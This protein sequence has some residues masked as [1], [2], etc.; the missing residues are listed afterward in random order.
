MLLLLLMYNYFIMMNMPLFTEYL[1]NN[2]MFIMNNN[3]MLHIEDMFLMMLA[4]MFLHYTVS[5][6]YLLMSLPF[7]SLSFLLDMLY[8]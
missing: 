5:Y 8:N 1:I 3:F 7:M 4:N 2:E 6:T